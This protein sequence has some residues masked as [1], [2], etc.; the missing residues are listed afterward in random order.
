[1][2]IEFVGIFATLFIIASMCFKTTSVKGSV[3][4]RSLN[5]A[6]CVIDIS[7]NNMNLHES[8]KVMRGESEF[9][10]QKYT[11]YTDKYFNFA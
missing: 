11:E 7:K 5:I 8:L 4:M 2:V 9:Y 1:M 6:G 3:I 10:K